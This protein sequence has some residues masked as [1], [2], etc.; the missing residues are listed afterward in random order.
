M[1]HEQSPLVVNRPFSNYKCNLDYSNSIGIGAF[2]LEYSSRGGKLNSHR[3][4]MPN[5]S[6]P[7]LPHTPH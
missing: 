2:P 3:P 4:T 1:L 6:I 5:R 7:P